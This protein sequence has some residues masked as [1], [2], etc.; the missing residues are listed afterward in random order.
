MAAKA[1]SGYSV[2]LAGPGMSF[3]RPVSEEI[4]NRIINLVMTGTT[5][6]PQHAQGGG[7]G[8]T[9]GN[10]GGAVANL[11]QGQLAGI[12]IRQFIAQK[13]PENMYQRIA[14]LAYYLTHALNT[15]HFKTKEISK[16]NTAAAVSKLTNPSARVND[17]TSKYGYLSQVRGG[18]KQIT[19]FGE[20]VVEALPDYDRVK[21]LHT[22]NRSR[23]RKKSARKKKSR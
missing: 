14:C 19:V 5:G 8:G 17:A 9:P 4:A 18:Q 3:D 20:H 6:S 10:T 1:D 21:Q 13:R 16:A 12:T 7:G 2:K 22:D 23:V 15:P 11:N